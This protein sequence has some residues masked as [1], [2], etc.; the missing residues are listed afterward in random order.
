M[1][2]AVTGIKP[3]G[4]PHLGNYLG[5]IRPALA[6]AG[7]HRACYFVADAHALITTT[8]GRLLRG[9][10]RRV[11]AAWLA[12]GLDPGR[13]L[14]YRQSDLPEVYELAWVLACRTGKG[15]L[16]RAHAYKAANAA[17]QAAGRDRDH[18]VSAGLFTYPVLMA[19]DVL[20]LGAVAVPVG[21][22]QRQHVEIARAIAGAVNA[23]YGPLLVTPEALVTPGVGTVPGLDGRKMSKSHGNELP[24]LAEPAELRR[25]VGRIVTD[26]R[27]PEQPKDPDRCTLFALYRRLAAPADVAALRRRYLAGGVAYRQVKEELAE[28]L[29]ARFAPA[30]AAYRELLGDPA[31]LER[32]LAAGAAAARDLAAPRLERLRRATGLGPL[33]GGGSAVAGLG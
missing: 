1:D 25:R 30:R 18:G 21:D 9:L 20:L 12:L 22:D 14:L 5:M 7:S 13:S 8:D 33:S 29:V 16:N 17:N 28:L 2:I 10:T 24:V 15:L 32:V 26:S 27:R 19:A 4:D 11:A 6:L 23:A 3:T 31:T